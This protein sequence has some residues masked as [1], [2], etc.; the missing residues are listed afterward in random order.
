[1]KVTASPV[2]GVYAAALTPRRDGEA[3]IDLAAALDL[4]DFLG[5]SGVDGI[6]L[7]GST[8]EFL[9]FDLEDRRH[10]IRFA[11]KRSPVPVVVNA[12]H[13]T[14]DGALNLAREAASDGAAGV[15]LLPPHFFR[16]GQQEIRAF[17]LQFAE[18]ME[19]ETPIL[20]YNVPEHA[21]AIQVDTAIELLSTGRFAGIKDSSGHLDDLLRLRAVRERVP[22]RLLVGNDRILAPAREAGADGAVSGVASAV[23][24]LV[25]GLDRAVRKGQVGPRQRLEARLQEFLAWVER[26]PTPVA[27][28][29]AARAR[30]IKTGPHAVP[31]GDTGQRHLEEFRK[32]FPG[33][34][35]SV[36]QEVRCI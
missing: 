29:E 30:G 35:R 10:L 18:D 31:L 34:W 6:A 32:W 7:L 9:H 16:Y 23:P 8:G 11:L 28:R 17:Y 12:S 3:T 36:E 25:C 13:S 1:M 19:A 21:G 15:L 26:F 4:I 14:I 33:W 27:I 22:F 2:Q 5:R 24:E 20:L